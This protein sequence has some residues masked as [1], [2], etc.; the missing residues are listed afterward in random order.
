ML[1]E[2]APGPARIAAELRGVHQGLM[3]EYSKPMLALA[4]EHM[5][6]AGLDSRWEFLHWNAFDLPTLQYQCDFL[7][8]F[9]FIRHFQMPDRSRLYHGIYSSLRPGGLF[10]LDVVNRQV[11]E[12]VDAKTL[13]SSNAQLQVYDVTY[14]L[15]EFRQEIENYGFSL[16][17]M[18]PVVR[19]FHLQSLVSYTLDHRSKKLSKLIVYTLEFLPSKNP[20]EW[21]A[22]AQK[23]R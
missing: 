20:L 3:I 13:Q 17:S 9:R 21:I 7:Y 19:N 18:I 15:D 5:V 16:I 22:V 10:M 2:L 6:R 12:R 23:K 8:T 1:V 11:R 14:T 4:R